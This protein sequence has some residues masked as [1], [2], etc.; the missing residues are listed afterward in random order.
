LK[1]TNVE[2]KGSFP[3]EAKSP[4][5][6]KPEY[7]FIGRSNVGKSSLIN[8]LCGRKEIA[9]VSK[10]PGKTQL[11]NY[12]EINNEWHLVDLPGFGYAKISKKK[13]REFELMINH[14]LTKR[15]D[16]LCSFVLLDSRIP[17]QK[18]DLDFINSLGEKG[19]P[20]VIVFTKIDGIK[21]AKLK[22]YI[23]RIE[24]DLLQYWNELPQRFLTSSKKKIGK[25][26]ILNFI[27]DLNK[28]L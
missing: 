27:E 10:T 11:I 6:G 8:M 5:L 26:E 17:L 24:D 21:K 18:V 25:E 2:F 20:F 28:K 19:I 7:A 3:S 23:K 4:K 14:Y 16:L 12:F 15:E 22:D 13:R 9:R 1:I